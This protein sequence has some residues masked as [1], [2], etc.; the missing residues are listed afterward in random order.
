MDR[1]AP[2]I[3]SIVG[4]S[5]SGKT[6]FILKLLPELKKRGLRVA[7]AKHCPRGF[8]LDIE[9]KDSYRFAQAG[10][11]GT[12]L[13]SGE[14]MA[15]IRPKDGP[16]DLKEMIFKNFA[17]FDIVL[18]EGYNDEPGIAKIRIIRKGIGG[19]PSDA[20]DVAAYLSDMRITTKKPVYDLNNIGHVISFIEDSLKERNTTE[21]KTL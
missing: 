11:G 3:L 18:T 8:D 19:T 7:V 10:S 15:V 21:A 17:D 2:F 5:D 20:D 12:Y 1:K 6:T 16:L 4:V 13:S 9:G 14:D